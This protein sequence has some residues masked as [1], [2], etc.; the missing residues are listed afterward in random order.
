MIQEAVQVFPICF[1]CHTGIKQGL[2]EDMFG[3]SAGSQE[4]SGLAQKHAQKL[5]IDQA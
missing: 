1:V 2:Q 5:D 4:L 3:C